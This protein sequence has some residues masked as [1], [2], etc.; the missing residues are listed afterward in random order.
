MS[1]ARTSSSPKESRQFISEFLCFFDFPPS[2]VAFDPQAPKKSKSD[3]DFGVAES[4]EQ[5]SSPPHFSVFRPQSPQ[6]AL[7]K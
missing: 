2:K 6:Q 3:A 7:F 5:E 4:G 1:I